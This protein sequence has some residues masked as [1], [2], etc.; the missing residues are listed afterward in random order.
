MRGLNL[1]LRVRRRYKTPL[2]ILWEGHT[3]WTYALYEDREGKKR[4]GVIKRDK[5]R[6]Y[7]LVSEC[8]ILDFEEKVIRHD[9]PEDTKDYLNN[10]RWEKRD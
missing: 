6:L 1:G 7:P 5:T 9:L 4:F 2:T 10:L 8:R 3:M